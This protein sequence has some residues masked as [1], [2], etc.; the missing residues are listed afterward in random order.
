MNIKHKAVVVSPN[1][2]EK[3]P[4][5]VLVPYRSLFAVQWIMNHPIDVIKHVF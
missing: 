1:Y 4:S 2:E 5:P 3:K